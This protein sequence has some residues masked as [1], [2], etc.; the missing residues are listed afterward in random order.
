MIDV[1]SPETSAP[2]V[3]LLALS[4]GMP[5]HLGRHRGRP[6][7]SGF[8]KHQVEGD[9]VSIG[10]T[11]IRGDG[12][13]DLTVHGGPE[14]AVY[15]YSADWHEGWLAAA[16]ELGRIPPA[17]FGENLTVAGWVEPDVWIGDIWAW[18]AARLQVCQPRWPCF[19]FSLATGHPKF[20]KIMLQNG[21][22][23]WYF[24]VLAPG[25]APVRGPIAVSERSS[26]EITVFD[27][28]AAMMPGADRDLVQRVIAAPALAENWRKSLIQSLDSSRR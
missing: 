5:S 15:A 23:G 3:R 9:T 24:R 27:A 21:W 18:G 19:K 26:D 7:E 20:G 11:N 22:T 1:H 12:Q 13:A 28:H 17:Y 6:V 8:R 14:K 2:E 10:L 16:P 4:V 25:D